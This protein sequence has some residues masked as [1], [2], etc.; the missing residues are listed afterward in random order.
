MPNM[1]QVKWIA[2]CK[3]IVYIYVCEYNCSVFYYYLL[4]KVR[5]SSVN[6]LFSLLNSLRCMCAAEW[7]KNNEHQI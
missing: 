1:C 7:Q 4:V 2:A 3:M 5:M 6:E